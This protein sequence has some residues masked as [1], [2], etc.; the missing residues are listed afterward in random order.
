MNFL[1]RCLELDP[2]KRGS[3]DDLLKD[4]FIRKAC[5]PSQFAEFAL[6]TLNER[7]NQ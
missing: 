1:K 5:T 3:A 6:F 7:R 2:F 4:P